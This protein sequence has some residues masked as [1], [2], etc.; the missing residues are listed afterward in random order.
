[1]RKTKKTVII[2]FAILILIIFSPY[3]KAE[4]LTLKYGNEFIGLEKETNMLN[5]AKYHKVFSYSKKQAGFIYI[6]Q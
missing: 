5:Q 6:S 2:I 4:Y 3:I 1:M